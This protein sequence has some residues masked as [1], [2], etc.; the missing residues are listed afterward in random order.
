ME[1]QESTATET[2]A[3]PAEKR[4]LHWEKSGPAFS[5][6][7]EDRAKQEIA[8]HALNA[9]GE[10][11]SALRRA[12]LLDLIRTWPRLLKVVGVTSLGAR[13][14]PR[15]GWAFTEMRESVE[16]A[17]CYSHDPYSIHWQQA[18]ATIRGYCLEVAEGIESRLDRSD[19]SVDS[20]RSAECADLF[21]AF[22]EGRE[23]S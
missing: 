11:L 12:V 9:A 17:M 5:G 7:A 8:A 3:Q 20:V 15:N 2:E 4:L 16:L 18:D 6:S 13:R 10:V 21:R 14:S 1:H 23:V 19:V 22:G